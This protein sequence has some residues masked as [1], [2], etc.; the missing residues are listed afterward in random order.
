M[1]SARR[2]PPRCAVEPP[3]VFTT[4]RYFLLTIT[5]YPDFLALSEPYQD[6][7][8]EHAS[9]LDH[10]NDA[11]AREVLLQNTL[12]HQLEQALRSYFEQTEMPFPM[13]LIFDM[14][15]TTLPD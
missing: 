6:S 8:L 5:N 1:A 10:P 11:N 2:H 3:S 7:V 9:M 12:K 15:D 14:R 4:R 13:T